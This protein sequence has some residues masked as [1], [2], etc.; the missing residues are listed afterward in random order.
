[1]KKNILL[2][3]LLLFLVL[4]NGILLFLVLKKPNREH[5]QP[6]D[7]I[8]KELAFNENQLVK[9]Q[10]FNDKHH[11]KMSEIEAESRDLKKYLFSNVGNVNLTQDKLDSITILIAKLGVEKE[12]EIFSFFQKIET[13]SNS[14]QKIKLKKIVKGALKGGR[15]RNGPPPPPRR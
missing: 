8:V 9:F 12:K 14:E 7:I 6:K 5:R 11:Y 15:E 10:E 1:M 3:I 13:I 4:M 2:I